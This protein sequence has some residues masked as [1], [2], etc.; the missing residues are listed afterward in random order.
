MEGSDRRT[1]PWTGSGLSI[2]LNAKSLHPIDFPSRF[3]EPYSLLSRFRTNGF[4]DHFRV[5]NLVVARLAA[6]HYTKFKQCG[7][8]GDSSQPGKS[9]AILARLRTN[10]T[11]VSSRRS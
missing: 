1:H 7:R 4:A 2:L 6:Q 8:I 9:N 11:G 5:Y 3:Q 10:N